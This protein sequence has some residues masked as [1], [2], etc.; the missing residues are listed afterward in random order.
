MN[1]VFSSLATPASSAASTFSQTGVDPG[2]TAARGT[3]SSDA[4]R[5]QHE[6]ARILAGVHD[7][8]AIHVLETAI[9]EL[10]HDVAAVADD[11][12]LHRRAQHDAGHHGER[13]REQQRRVEQ[14]ARTH[15]ATKDLAVVVTA[16]QRIL[17]GVTD[18]PFRVTHLFHH[19]VA[20]IHACAA[21]D[22]FVLQPVPDVD[23]GRADLD[24][25]AAIDAVAEA[26]RAS[27]DRPAA[28]AAGV[29]S[30]CI[31]GNDQRVRIEHDALEA[32]IRTHVLAHLLAHEARVAPGGESVEQHPE[33]LPGP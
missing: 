29:A 10:T 18:Q 28:R 4:A 31:V 26:F 6:A 23:A 2:A 21:A 5:R 9:L 19:L 33:R 17:G 27:I 16:G 30:A 20:A 14:R 13:D 12:H 24:A 25:D 32:R 11:V 1:T 15:Q 22:A 3:R 7:L 8:D